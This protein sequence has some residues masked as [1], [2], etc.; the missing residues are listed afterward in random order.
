MIQQLTQDDILNFT[1]PDPRNGNPSGMFAVGGD[2]RVPRLLAA[3]RQGIFP[4]FAFMYEYPMWCCPMRRFVIFPNEVHV[5]HSMRN[6]FNKNAYTVTMDHAFQDMI[7]LCAVADGRIASPDAWL[8]DR[9]IT[10]YSHL[11]RRGVAHSVE[12]WDNATGELV[13]GLYGELTGR[14]F[15]GESMCSIKPN[16]SKAALITLARAMAQLP[17][18]MIIDT[19]IETPHLKSLGSRYIDYDD[20]LTYIDD[21][22]LAAPLRSIIG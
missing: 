9:L 20:Y 15:M 14:C 11:F 10:V 5:S 17:Q 22:D 8:G 6:L 3:F 18:P 21:S 12:V 2:L 4:W 13:G 7:R 16:A 1:F 19:Q